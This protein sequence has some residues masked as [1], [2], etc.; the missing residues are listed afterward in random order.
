[1]RRDAATMAKRHSNTDTLQPQ[2]SNHRRE[3]TTQVAAEAVQGECEKL[4]AALREM[5]RDPAT[6]HAGR[7]D[8]EEAAAASKARVHRSQHNA[9]IEH[10]SNRVPHGATQSKPSNTAGLH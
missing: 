5:R 3:P 1:M 9:Q 8:E 10:H 2:I 4:Q 6:G 7:D